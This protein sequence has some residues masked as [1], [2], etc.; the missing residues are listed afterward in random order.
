MEKLRAKNKDSSQLV[1][2]QADM[3]VWSGSR[4]YIL[5]PDA[6]LSF[7]FKNYS[8]LCFFFC[9]FVSVSGLSL[10]AVS[11]NYSSLGCIGYSLW[12]LLLLWS[13]GSRHMG[14]SDVALGL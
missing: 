7:V 5:K 14:F 4:I 8:F 1:S 2:C 10:V 11:G 9:V 6:I 13:T 3:W 12:C